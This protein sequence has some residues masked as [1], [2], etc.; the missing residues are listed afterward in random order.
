MPRQS[1]A[2]KDVGG[3]DKPRGA[4]NQALIRGYLNG[5]THRG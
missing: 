4:A 1:E 2:T 3:C 5:E